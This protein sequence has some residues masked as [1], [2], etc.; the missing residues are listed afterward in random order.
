MERS[1]YADKL[2]KLADQI[3]APIN[4]ETIAAPVSVKKVRR[5]LASVQSPLSVV[6][7]Q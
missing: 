7:L 2:L 1:R 3:A 6:P 5:T 4:P